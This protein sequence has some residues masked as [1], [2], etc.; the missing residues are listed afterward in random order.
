MLGRLR[1]GGLRRRGRRPRGGDHRRQHLRLHRPRQAGVDRHH[2]GDGARE[3]SPAGRGGWWSRAASPSATTPSCAGR[4]PRSTPPWAPGQVDDILRAVG[5]RGHHR[6][7]R[8]ACPPGS[9]TT[10]RPRV[11]ST[12]RYMAYVKISE[13]CDYT[14]SFCIIPDPPRQ[15]PQPQRGGHRERGA[16][17]GRAG[18]AR[19]RARGPGLDALR[20]RPRHPRRPRLPA[21]AARPHRRHPLDPRDVRLPGHP[22]RRHPGRDRRRGEGR[23][24]R[25]HPA[26]ARERGR[27]SSG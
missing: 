24:V 11:L 13:G 25:G 22:Q 16:R 1:A 18:R 4:S 14:C 17:A 15:E 20:P 5:G 6:R 2:P 8:P 19:D 26:P 21:A 27:C 9:T 3:G 7:R 10:P 12:P 23:Q